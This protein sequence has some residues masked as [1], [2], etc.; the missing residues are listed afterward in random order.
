MRALVSYVE[1]WKCKGVC[2]LTDWR[3]HFVYK[4]VVL[5]YIVM[6]ISSVLP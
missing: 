6:V 5:M 3:G 1:E 4:T 2:L